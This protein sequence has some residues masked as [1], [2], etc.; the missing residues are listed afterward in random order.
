M[1]LTCRSTVLTLRTS[2]AA[3]A[4]LVSPAARGAQDL[5]L[6][7]GE[8]MSRLPRRAPAS[9]PTRA[10]S[11]PRR[12]CAKVSRAAS[13]S[14]VARVLV[15]QLPAGEPDQLAD[16]RGLVRRLE[17]CHSSAA[18]RSEGRAARAS[19]SASRTAPRACA[20]IASSAPA[21]PAVGD[22]ARARRR[23]RAAA[24]RSSTAS[25]TSTNAGSSPARLPGSAAS[26][27]TLRIAG[28]AASPFPAPA[29]S[30]RGP[31]A[32]PSHGRSPPGRPPRPRGGRRSRRWT[33][34]ALV[35]GLAGCRRVLSAQAALGGPACLLDRLRPG[36]VQLHD[37]A[38]DG[39]GS[40]R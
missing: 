39:R 7:L 16:P 27:S 12:G 13:S 4:L 17:R 23:R 8:P 21:P 32:A 25:M 24:S 20:A 29:A 2:S 5:E 22:R 37:L 18:L 14:S 9:V 26:A 34:P 28:C 3:I 1:L 36:A 19:P 40:G 38:R 35:A 31:A 10:R 33:S 11:V 15:P 30:G 6:A